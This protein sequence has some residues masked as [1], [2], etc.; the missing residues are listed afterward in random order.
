MNPTTQA[1]LLLTAHLD[2]HDATKPLSPAEWGRLAAHLHRHQH[3]PADLLQH[4]L[5]D[6]LDGWA[7]KTVSIDRYNAAAVSPSPWKNGSG[8][9]FASSP[10]PIRPTRNA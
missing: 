6:L 1:I 4:A 5:R 8:L 7:D 3:T 9:V 10:A 2:K